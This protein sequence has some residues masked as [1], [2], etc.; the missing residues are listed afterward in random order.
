M[1]DELINKRVDASKHAYNAVNAL[2]NTPIDSE[3]DSIYKEL[4]ASHYPY[5][6]FIDIN[7][8][9]S[10]FKEDNYRDFNRISRYYSQPYMLIK[11]YSDSGLYNAS[12]EKQQYDKDKLIYLK[13]MPGK[14][15]KENVRMVS[16]ALEELE[17]LKGTFLYPYY[18]EDLNRMF[19]TAVLAFDRFGFQEISRSR[20]SITKLRDSIALH[21]K[22]EKKV[23][24]PIQLIYNH[25]FPGRAYTCDEIKKKLQKIYDMLDLDIKAKATD[26]HQYFIAIYVNKYLGGKSNRALHLTDYV[27]GMNPIYTRH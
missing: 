12:Y 11:A 7:Q 6:S 20:F 13:R 26:I 8:K 9:Y 16:E 25:F 15:S 1:T 18:R 2:R 22:Q 17:S 27:V 10:S 4:M 3:T 21:D 19:P 23:R 14:Y 5:S 24:L